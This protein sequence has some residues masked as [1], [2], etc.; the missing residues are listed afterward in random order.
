MSQLKATLLSS[1]IMVF[2]IPA[3]PAGIV[4]KYTNQSPVTTFAVNF[5]A[6]Y[7]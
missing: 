6:I 4:V 3:V 7:R 2:L 1:W 5:I